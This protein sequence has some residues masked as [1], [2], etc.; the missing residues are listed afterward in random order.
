[1]KLFAVGTMNKE[2]ITW[3]TIEAESKKEAKHQTKHLGSIIKVSEI[4]N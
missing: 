3:T 1:M 2:G 4:T